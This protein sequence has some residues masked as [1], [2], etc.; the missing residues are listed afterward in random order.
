MR[1]II[2]ADDFGLTHSVNRA[3]IEVFQLGNLNSTTLMV[4]MPGTAEAVQL[5]N[6]HRTLNVGLHFCITEGKAVAGPSTLTHP[7]GSFYSRSE[8]IKRSY[9]NK[10]NARDIQ[11]EFEAQLSLFK[12]FGLCPTHTD[13]H[14]H[15]HNTPFIFKS[16]LPNLQK[17]GLPVRT[18]QPKIQWELLKKRPVKLLKQILLYQTVAGLKRGPKTITN[19]YLVSLHDLPVFEFSDP[20]VYLELLKVADN[21]CIIELM[22]HP[23][24]PGEDVKQLY[25]DSYEQHTAFIEK[26]VMEYKLL[27]QRANIFSKYNLIGYGA[28]E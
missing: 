8:L 26:C 20:Q 14:Q 22:I 10:V 15:V 2:N 19:D 16:I 13:S 24:I 12:S 27:T 23:Y 9:L 18:V 25:E 3:I 5:A 4:N 17:E 28:I 11:M 21:N 1:L 7:D 6:Q